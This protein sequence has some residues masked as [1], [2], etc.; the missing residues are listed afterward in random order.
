MPSL[1]NAR[2]ERFCQEVAVNGQKLEKA[3]EIAG[4]RPSRKN[5][6]ALRQRKDIS[7]RIEALLAARE[8]LIER[9]IQRSVEK[10]AV[11]RAD[12][13]RRLL[14]L[15]EKA[16]A[17]GQHGPAVRAAELLGKEIGMFVDRQLRKETDDIFESMGD[18]DLRREV[19][20]RLVAM[21][22]KAG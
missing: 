21:Q 10:S 15:S 2:H 6:W 16:E 18:A 7:G 14:H 9:E 8:R 5:A 11:T 12:I 1:Y 3:Y 20:E 13:I 4:F 17:D 22:H 19:E